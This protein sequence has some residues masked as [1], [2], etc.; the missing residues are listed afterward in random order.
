[1]GD[2]AFIAVMGRSKTNWEALTAA[3]GRFSLSSISEANKMIKFGAQESGD[4]GG[5]IGSGDFNNDGYSDLILS[6]SYTP[7]FSYDGEVYI[8]FGRSQT[9]WDAI[10]DASGFYSLTGL[11]P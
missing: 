8:I 10:T 1:M 6:S 4:Y 2:P 7:S 11:N 3:N 9:D 5:N